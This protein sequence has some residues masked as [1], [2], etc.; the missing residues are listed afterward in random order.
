LGRVTGGIEQYAKRS[1]NHQQWWRIKPAR[2]AISGI[3]WLKA[4]EGANDSNHEEVNRFLSLD[5]QGSDTSK[6]IVTFRKEP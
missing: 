6:Q 1:N 4:A 5:A 3:M 2:L